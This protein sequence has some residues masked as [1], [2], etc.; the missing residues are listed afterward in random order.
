MSL[1]TG[2]F[3]CPLC[4]D[5]RHHVLAISLGIAAQDPAKC[6]VLNVI[7]VPPC[8]D[9]LRLHLLERM[10]MTFKNVRESKN[11]IELINEYVLLRL[12]VRLS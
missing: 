7:H 12:E 4:T 8:S 2:C 10:E 11:F 9:S 3:S 5:M 6:G 1:F